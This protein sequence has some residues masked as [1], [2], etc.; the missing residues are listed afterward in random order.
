M[1]QSLLDTDYYKL[2]MAQVVLRRFRRTQVRYK[3]ICRDKSIRFPDGFDKNLQH[4][5]NELTYLTLSESE[6]KWLSKQKGISQDF[7]DWFANYRFN[8]KEVKVRLD[9]GNLEIDIEGSWLTTI[10]WEVPLMAIISELYFR[11]QSLQITTQKMINTSMCKKYD[12]NIPFADFG[13]RRRYSFKSHDIL[14]DIMK[15]WPYFMGTSNPYLAKKYN[16]PVI[17]TYAHEAIM[18]METL[19]G[20]KQSNHRWITNWR[21]IYGDLYNIALT[22]TYTTP[23][24]FKTVPENLIWAIDGLRQ[25]SGNPIEIGKLIINNYEK[26]GINPK[27]KTIIFS[28]NLNPEKA[29]KL[30]KYFKDKIKI[31]FGIG[32][33]LTND[34]VLNHLN[35][36]IKI[37]E[38]W[39]EKGIGTGKYKPTTKLSDDPMK[40]IGNKNILKDK[41]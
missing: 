15:D 36:V 33:N 21:Y 9:N 39:D 10:F 20:V 23:Y 16:V 13:T 35:M 17:G 7:V 5:I 18:V 11:H 26:M 32:T 22:D 6:A 30:Y 2:T 4:C 34:F 40:M 24:F 38:V 19:Y 41:I 29:N 27:T 12:L 28:D 3:F 31:V 14:I 37:S 1:I 25:D 8:P